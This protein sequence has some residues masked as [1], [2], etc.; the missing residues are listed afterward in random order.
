MLILLTFRLYHI[1]F[2]SDLVNENVTLKAG[3]TLKNEC[4]LDNEL[5]FQWMQIIHAIPLS[6]KQKI[7]DS[8]NKC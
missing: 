1:D 5:Y 3:K 6:W 7:N 8:E 4:H 2:V